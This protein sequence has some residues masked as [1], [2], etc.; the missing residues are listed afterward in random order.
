MTSKKSKQTDSIDTTVNI[1]HDGAP[2]HVDAEIYIEMPHGY[3]KNSWGTTPV[4]KWSLVL[5]K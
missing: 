4:S 3:T 5:R 1:C 2:K